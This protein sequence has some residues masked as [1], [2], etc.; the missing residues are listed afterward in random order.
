MDKPSPRLAAA[1]GLFCP[2]CTIYIGTQEDPDR[3]E[4]SAKLR[5]V[6]VETLR[7]DGCRAERRSGYCRT[8]TLI[9][10]ATEKGIEF[11]VECEDYPC[12]DL[13]RFQAERPH[14][15]MLF[16]DLERIRE[17]G[18][19]DWFAEKIDYYSC[20]ECGTL[21]SAYDFKCR[22]CGHEPSCA[23]VAEHGEAV[24]KFLEGLS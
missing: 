12:E 9:R 1:C 11:C 13:K 7:C 10:C 3:L 22:A 6:D 15:R 2:A 5:G 23:Y 16:P 8:C 24:R 14:R 19:E 20:P 21:N 17:I 18:F 4:S